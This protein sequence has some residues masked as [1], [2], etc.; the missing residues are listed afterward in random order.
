M[1]MPAFVPITITEKAYREIHYIIHNK[2]IPEDYGL[3]VGI[4]GG[5]CSGVS[6]ILGF[7]KKKTT[8][9][10]YE[11]RGI[12]I[13][14]AKKHTMFVMGLEIDFEESAEVRGFTFSPS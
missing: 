4:S 9:D 1:N 8:D 14:M 6:Y 10:E 2:N 5:G 3:R 12:R 7:D 11:I 13:F